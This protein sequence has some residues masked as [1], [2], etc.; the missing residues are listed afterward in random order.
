MLPIMAKHAKTSTV[1]GEHSGVSPLTGKNS[2]A[3]TTSAVK[4]HLLKGL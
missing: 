1:V 4:G 2:K 3:K